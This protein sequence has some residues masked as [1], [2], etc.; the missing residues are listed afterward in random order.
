VLQRQPC[1]QSLPQAALLYVCNISYMEC[2][3][4]SIQDSLLFLLFQFYV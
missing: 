1:T 2:L 3:C 4:K